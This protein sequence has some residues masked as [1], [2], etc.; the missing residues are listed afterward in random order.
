M[1]NKEQVVLNGQAVSKDEVKK[2]QESAPK[3]ERIVEVTPNEF[4]TLKKMNG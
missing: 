4:R 2:A 1:E 3:S